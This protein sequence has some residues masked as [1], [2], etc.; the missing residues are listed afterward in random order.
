MLLER[1]DV[2]S[3][4]YLTSKNG[5]SA[6]RLTN[7]V[8]LI[9]K[10]KLEEK[11]EK[12]HNLVHVATWLIVLAIFWFYN[13]LL[14]FYKLLKIKTKFCKPSIVSR[15]YNSRT[16]IFYKIKIFLWLNIFFINIVGLYEFSDNFFFVCFFNN[17][18]CLKCI[19]NF[20]NSI[21]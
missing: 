14:S 17:S 18:H 2:V 21:K 6:H 12:I 5:I 15:V 4:N 8:D 20:I 13:I 11:K 16:I 10:A 9:K 1:G 3:R 7:V 19:A